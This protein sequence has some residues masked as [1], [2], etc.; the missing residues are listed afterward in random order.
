MKRI[1]VSGIIAGFTLL[2]FCIIGLY[3][4]SWLFPEMAKRFYSPVLNAN[5]GRIIIYSVH[6]MITG[7]ALSWFWSRF[8]QSLTGSFISRG[9]EFGLI[10]A[11]IAIVPVLWLVYSPLNA[12]FTMVAGWFGFWVFQGLVAGLVFEKTNP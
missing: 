5:A 6:P 2:I 9:I 10:Y 1:F 8:K 3:L 11:L 7:L 4:A 12:S